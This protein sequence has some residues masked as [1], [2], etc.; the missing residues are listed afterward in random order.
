M[1]S[2]CVLIK[3]SKQQPHE[4]ASN[5]DCLMILFVQTF[6]FAAEPF[7]FNREKQADSRKIYSR[8]MTLFIIAVAVMFLI[9]VLYMH[10]F[11]YFIG[12]QYWEALSIVPILLLA[13]FSLGVYWNL[14]MWFKLSKQTKWGA[15]MAGIG[16][17]ITLVG[18][19][20]FIPTYGYEACAWVTFVSYVSLTVLSYFLGQKHYPI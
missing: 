2:N 6:R 12:K 17:V 8:S 14:N 16:A 11:K 4:T 20:I 18:N 5:L 15:I 9:I 19:W 7:F 10:V 1:R 3:R 13:N